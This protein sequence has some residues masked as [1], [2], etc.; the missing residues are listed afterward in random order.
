MLRVCVC[1]CVHAHAHKDLTLKAVCEVEPYG[2]RLSFSH[3]LCSQN[4]SVCQQKQS[5]CL[6][7]SLVYFHYWYLISSCNQIGSSHWK[8]IP[9]FVL[10]LLVMVLLIQINCWYWD[11][12]VVK[13][14]LWHHVIWQIGDNCRSVWP[15]FYVSSTLVMEAACSS[16]ILYASTRLYGVIT[17]PVSCEILKIC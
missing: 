1:V 8:W 9:V 12:T 3:I 16:E 15:Q 10:E 11:C 6:Y 5:C 17:M 7:F 4:V 14:R 2:M 13:S